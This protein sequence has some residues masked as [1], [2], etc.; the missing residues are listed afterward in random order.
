MLVGSLDLEE[1]CHPHCLWHLARTIYF[2]DKIH[3]YQSWLLWG[4]VVIKCHWTT[5]N[6][7]AVVWGVIPDN[8][9]AQNCSKL[10][11]I[12]NGFCC[13][14]EDTTC[15]SSIRYCNIPGLETNCNK[16]VSLF[17][18]SHC[19]AMQEGNVHSWVLK[20]SVNILWYFL[21]VQ[22]D[23]GL[24]MHIKTSVNIL[25]HWYSV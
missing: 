21:H 19:L 11:Q 20:A 17:P 5:S 16:S 15:Q 3:E 2:T 23:F 4:G 14:H 24:S 6:R 1:P 25:W 12:A 8:W 18:P 7:T 13:S 22:D 9:S 10:T